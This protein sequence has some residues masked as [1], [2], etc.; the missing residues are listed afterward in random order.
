MLGKHEPGIGCFKELCAG[1]GDVYTLIARNRAISYV[2]R[3]DDRSPKAQGGPWNIHR[4]RGKEGLRF[5]CASG[6]GHALTCDVQTG[7]TR[8]TFESLLA[9]ALR[10]AG[11]VLLLMAAVCVSKL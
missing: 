6:R 9:P 7:R 1:L 2:D 11:S 8:S 10:A 5:K 4:G 3:Y